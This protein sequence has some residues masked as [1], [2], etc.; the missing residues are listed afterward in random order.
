LSIGYQSAFSSLFPGINKTLRQQLKIL[1]K[2]Q[3]EYILY[4]TVCR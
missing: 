2:I 1:W 4:H 3:W